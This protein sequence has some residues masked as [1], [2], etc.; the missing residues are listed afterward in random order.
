MLPDADMERFLVDGYVV[1]PGAVPADVIL[2][3]QDVVW[4]ELSSRGVERGDRSTWTQPVV[5][6]ST[7][8]VSP[9]V[10][11]GTS[12]ALWEAYDQ[13]LGDGRWSKRRGVGGTIPVRFPSEADPGDAGWHIDGS[14]DGPDGSYWV[15][16]RS[17]LRGLLVLFLLTDVD[18]GSAPTRILE[19]SHLDVPRVLAPAGD[20]GMSFGDVAPRLPASTFE[21]R[22][23]FAVGRAGDV[24]VCHPFLVH[25]ASW[26]HRG[27]QPRMIAQPGVGILEPF[28]LRAGVEVCP[29]EAA[30]L[31][32][33]RDQK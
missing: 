6:L 18:E 1:L 16:A 28:A 20:E 32:G 24:Y 27:T 26:P 9:F 15:N 30:I 21:R 5:R 23:V 4:R 22:R 13:L 7:P 14:F 12:P 2:E 19:G 8:D 31:R 25:A 33:L 29:V 3:C 11:A 10:A 17:K